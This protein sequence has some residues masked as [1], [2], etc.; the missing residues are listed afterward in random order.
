MWHSPGA[1]PKCPNRYP[2][3]RNCGEPL[4]LH[5]WRSAAGFQIEF[6]NGLLPIGAP[7]IPQLAL[8]KSTSIV[9]PIPDHKGKP[10]QALGSIWG[11]PPCQ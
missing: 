1:G 11:K 10:A 9:M 6:G 8:T 2:Q 3:I 7:N 5:G 4:Q